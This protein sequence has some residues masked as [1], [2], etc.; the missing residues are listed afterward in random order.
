MLDLAAILE[1]LLSKV[2]AVSKRPAVPDELY[3]YTSTAC[4]HGILRSRKLW[5][6]YYGHMNDGSEFDYGL[7]EFETCFEEVR[8]SGALAEISGRLSDLPLWVRQLANARSE[9]LFC[10]CDR[11]NLISQWREYSKDTTSYAIGLDLRDEAIRLL[12]PRPVLI[13]VEYSQQ[14]QRT[15]I[16]QLLQACNSFMKHDAPADVAQQD[17]DVMKTAMAKLVLRCIIHFKHPA[18]EP[19]SEWRLV[20]GGIKEE[21]GPLAFRATR[22]GVSPYME[23][24]VD[25]GGLLPIRS[26]MIGPS[27][28]REVAHGTTDTFLKSCGY[29]GIPLYTSNI[30][31]RSL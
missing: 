17:M 25:G 15:R 27:A 30:P 16:H 23:V 18:F 7:S 31:I 4:F 26:V 6:T 19:E 14:S 28:F 12:S 8:Q 2:P 9:Y 5:L 11:K 10:L 20:L 13:K 24:A 21:L 1:H 3:H 22:M 29:A